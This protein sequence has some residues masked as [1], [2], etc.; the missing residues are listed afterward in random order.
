MKALVETA[1]FGLLPVP[2]MHDT[3]EHARGRAQRPVTQRD[4]RASQDA[5]LPPS[6]AEQMATNGELARLREELLSIGR[7]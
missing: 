1:V 3:E 2:P 5:E 6:F 7:D 4:D